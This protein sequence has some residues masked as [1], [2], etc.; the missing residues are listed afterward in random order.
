MNLVVHCKREPFD[1]LIDRSTMWGNPFSHKQG[2]KAKFLVATRAESI[3]KFEEWFLS[4]PGMVALAKQVLRGKVLG[5][6]CKPLA[7]HGDVLARI[8]NE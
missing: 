3:A 1:V 8:A 2:T 5:C 4:R 7:C 6:W